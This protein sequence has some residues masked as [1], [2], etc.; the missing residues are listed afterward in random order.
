MDK[1][2][3]VYCSASFEIDPKYNKVAREFVRAASL[4][5]YG[6]VSGGTIKGTMGEIS[7]E[8]RLC[9]GY[10]LGVIPRFME[11]YVYPDLSEV[12]WT[13]TMAERKSLLRKDTCAVVALPGGVGTLDEVIEVLALVHLKQYFGKIFLLNHEGFYE[14]LR[15]LLQHY[16]DA[17]ML[18]E[19][20]MEKV[21]FAQTPEE[22]LEELSR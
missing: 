13:D 2:I 4:R 20:T 8:L 16:V 14:P 19:A 10:H 7:D 17:K 18:S 21:I 3:A 12:I 1:K 15:N 6:V 22:I 5:G 11:Q 9:G